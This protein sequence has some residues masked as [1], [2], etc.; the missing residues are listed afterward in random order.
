M[1]QLTI[2]LTKPTAV[3]ILLAA[4]GSICLVFKNFGPIQLI[5]TTPGAEEPQKSTAVAS[6]QKPASPM[7]QRPASYPFM[8]GVDQSADPE[9]VKYVKEHVLIP[10]SEEEYKLGNPQLKDA[11]E[12]ESMSKIVIPKYFANVR[13]ICIDSCH[14]T[15]IQH[16]AATA[17]FV[18]A[19]M[20]RKGV[21]VEGGVVD[22]EHHSQ[23]LILEKELGWTG[24]I[25]DMNPLNRDL[26][27]GK[28]RKAYFAPVCL[29][30]QPWPV[31][32]SKHQRLSDEV[33][34][35]KHSLLSGS[36]KTAF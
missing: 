5:I 9:L 15:M 18:C 29:S 32:V 36:Q 27:L 7:I 31:K 3:F 22:G 19:Q 21:F 14:T 17:F 34:T 23:S 20:T 13:T 8:C 26:V 12:F 2:R 24:L 33:Q 30:Q 11:S 10:P 28:H 16:C 4:V 25:Y 1:T 35:V 6:E